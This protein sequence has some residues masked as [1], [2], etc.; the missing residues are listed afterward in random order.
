MSTA[1]DK[2]DTHEADARLGAA[3]RVVL[4][5][6][7]PQLA[8]PVALLLAEL[9]S[10]T[11]KAAPAPELV[12]E[13]TAARKLDVHRVTLQRARKRGAPHSCVGRGVRYDLDALRAWFAAHGTR[14]A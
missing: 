2:P 7:A 3:V 8:A 4:E 14:P 13:A 9:L 11:S 5:A 10:S 1:S 6:A 12:S